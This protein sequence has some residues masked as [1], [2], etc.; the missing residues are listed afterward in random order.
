MILVAVVD[1]D[2]KFM[3]VN[4]GAVDTGSDGNVFVQS[5]QPFPQFLLNL[6]R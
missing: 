1:A 4:I 3:F 5:Q 6:I 2:Y